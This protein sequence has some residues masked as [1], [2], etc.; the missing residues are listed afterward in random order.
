MNKSKFK[1][2]MVENGVKVADI[3]GLI[4]NDQSTVYRKMNLDTFTIEDV[5][6]IQGLLGLTWD[7][8]KDIFVF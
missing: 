5:H 3:A 2:K 7:D 4:G 8:I 6:R 1:A